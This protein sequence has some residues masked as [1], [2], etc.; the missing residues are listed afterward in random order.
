MTE[1]DVVARSDREVA[2]LVLERMLIR[3]EDLRPV[4]LLRFRSMCRSGGSMS[5]E[6]MSGA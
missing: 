2:S 4:C 5:N 1:R 3:R 6:T